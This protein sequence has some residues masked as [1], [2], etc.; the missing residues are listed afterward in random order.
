MHAHAD[1]ASAGGGSADDTATITG[2][3]T[4][5]DQAEPRLILNDYSDHEDYINSTKLAR[6]LKIQEGGYI[7]AE[8]VNVSFF[9]LSFAFLI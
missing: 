8:N 9:L 3:T 7:V 2:A 6:A 4:L 5:V 1:D